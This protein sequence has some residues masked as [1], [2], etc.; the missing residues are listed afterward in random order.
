MTDRELGVATA[1]CQC[2]GTDLP[3]QDLPD[4]G[5][6]TVRCPEC[7]PEPQVER[8]SEFVQT[9]RG[10]TPGGDVNDLGELGYGSDFI[11]DDDRNGDE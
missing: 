8:A 2:C 6:T 1:P 7:F 10:V 4:G 9:E 5:V 3:L 11:Y